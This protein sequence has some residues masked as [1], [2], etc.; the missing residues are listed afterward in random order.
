MLSWIMDE[1]IH[2]S[3]STFFCQQLVTQYMIEIW[4]ENHLISDSGC[5][6]IN[7]QSPKMTNNVGLAFSVTDTTP[8][9]TIN[10]E[11]DNENW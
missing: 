2:W 1:F 8:C 4:M 9:F 10:I 7:L 11:Q 6:N 3:K 5:N